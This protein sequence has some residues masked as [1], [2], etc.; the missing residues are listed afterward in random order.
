MDFYV[1]YCYYNY[2]IV[3]HIR[4][5][6]TGAAMLFTAILV[7]GGCNLL[8][9]LGVPGLQGP[10]APVAVVTASQGIAFAS[11]IDPGVPV[12]VD[13]SSSFDP[14]EDPFGISWQLTVPEG[15]SSQLVTSAGSRG[16]FTPVV[17]VEGTYVLSATL[18]DGRLSSE[19]SIT[20]N[21]PASGNVSGSLAQA[22][23]GWN[24]DGNTADLFSEGVPRSELN[25]GGGV[26]DEDRYGLA[27]SA[28]LLSTANSY[29]YGGSPGELILSPADATNG[30]FSLSVWIYFS[31][32]PADG[33][34][35]V[36][37]DDGDAATAPG[38]RLGSDSSGRLGVVADSDQFIGGI[39]DPAATFEVN[40]WYHLA[41]A[42]DQDVSQLD[43]YL[44]GEPVAE[45]V[46]VGTALGAIHN[47]AGQMQINGQGAAVPGFTGRLDDLVIFNAVLSQEEIDLLAAYE[48][49]PQ[50]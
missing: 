35:I 50:N 37:F 24:F 45:N 7:F 46:S 43:I 13:L 38:W 44:D 23:A 18:S 1:A 10:Q 31:V 3:H 40:S 12:I 47:T 14:N 8:T 29:F 5:T 25:G 26:Y 41:I 6:S 39:A 49:P 34:A 22:E 27:S 15:S 11:L 16:E 33:S 2:M 48:A 4:R 17:G 20:L 32:L 30:D 9:E 21:T 19:Y 36:S 28:L 42:Y